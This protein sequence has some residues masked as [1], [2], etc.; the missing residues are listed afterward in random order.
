M[1]IFADRFDRLIHKCPILDFKKSITL[2]EFFDEIAG[3]LSK[4]LKIK[5]DKICEL[6]WKREKEFST[7]IAPR[8]AI[9]HI[10]IPGKKRFGILLVRCREGIIFDTEFPSVNIAFILMGTKD[11]CNLHIKTLAAI[12]QIAQ[13]REFHEKWL[14]ARTIK[15]LRNVILLVERK[16]F[17]PK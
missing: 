13:D 16:R 17:G 10:I 8:L 4:R 5:K 15:E 3:V 14:K 12:A 2:N 1:K 9:P 6:L 11:E 7:V